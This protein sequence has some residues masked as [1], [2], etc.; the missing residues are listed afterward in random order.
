MTMLTYK[1]WRESHARFLI[2]GLVLIGIC[3][4]F[5][6]LQS[7]LRVQL[8]ARAAPF[9]TYAGY[10]YRMVYDGPVRALFLI[11]A[12]MLGLGGLQRERETQTVGFTLALPAHRWQLVAARAVT[13]VLE[14]GVLAL[15]PALLTPSLSLIVHEAYP[16]SQALEFGLLWAACGVAV[17]AASFLISTAFAGGYSAMASAFVVLFFYP[18]LTRLSL[19][20]DYPLNIHYIM[21]GRD[22][23]YFDARSHMLVGPPP[24]GLL[25]VVSL[26]ALGLLALA[27]LLTQNQEFP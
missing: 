8:A 20:R 27:A 24:W 15:L 7:S 21:S 25:S 13:G 18:P 9:K 14:I 26:V 3:L 23:P 6:M 12:M 16:V 11:F 22:M 10:I 19:L 1:A 17:F 2:S 4:A 5:V